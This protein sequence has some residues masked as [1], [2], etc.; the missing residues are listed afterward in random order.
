MPAESGERRNRWVAWAAALLVHGLM[1]QALLRLPAPPARL[2]RLERLTI[3]NLLP[4]ERAADE[5]VPVPR[6]TASPR[7]T[8]LAPTNQTGASVSMAPM[9]VPAPANPPPSIDWA[10]EQERA[11][12]SKGREIWQQLS[13]HCRDNAALHIYPPE[14]HRYV[15]PEPWEPE[16]SALDWREDC[17]TCIWVAVWWDLASGDARSVNRRPP[18]ATCSTACAI[19]IAR[20]RSP[21]MVAIRR[22]PGRVSRCTEAASGGPV[23][24][25]CL[26]RAACVGQSTKR[27]G[28]T[29][30][31]NAGGVGDDPFGEYLHRDQ[32]LAAKIGQSVFHLGGRDRG[33]GP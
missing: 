31:L 1:I 7:T 29:G 20:V 32:E 8:R 6:R 33:D 23:A 12:A 30:G 21:T 14:C 24:S 16:E 25:A 4:P 28:G 19:P 11:A 5:S 10:A 2:S 13:Q 26:L 17:P 18:T 27:K 22:R 3:L 9:T 15:A